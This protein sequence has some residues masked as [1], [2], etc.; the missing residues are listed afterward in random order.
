MKQ[1]MLLCF[2]LALFNNTRPQGVTLLYKGGNTDR[3]NDALNWVQINTPSGQTPIHQVPTELDAV[4][5][6]SAQSGL[7]SVSMRFDVLA[8]HGIRVGDTVNSGYR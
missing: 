8:P 5:F 6:S 2:C 7:S 3:W 1:A 4:V